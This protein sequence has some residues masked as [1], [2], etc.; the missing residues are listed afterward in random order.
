VVVA[1]AGNSNTSDIFYPAG[2][3]TVIAVGATDEN[4]KRANFS[5]YGSYIDVMA[6]GINIQTINASSTSAYSSA[7][8]TSMSCPLVAALCGLIRSQ[9][10]G[11]NPSEVKSR[12]QAGCDN[13]DAG[14]SGFEGKLGSGRINAFKTLN[15]SAHVEESID[16]KLKNPM[17]P[18]DEI[19]LPVNV[20]LDYFE[21][22]STSGVVLHSF[23]V[24]NAGKVFHLPHGI[25]QGFY[26]IRAGNDNSVFVFKVFV[27]D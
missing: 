6:P 12:L 16:I 11:L 3:S 26:L 21:V 9:Q 22:I 24:D 27:H 20:D 7:S 8:G 19:I 4:D 23:N 10:S 1:A 15:V 14:N 25:Q 17:S 2:Y 5:N 13:I 18:S